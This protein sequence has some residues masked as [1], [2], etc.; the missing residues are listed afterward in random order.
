MPGIV[1]AARRARRRARAGASSWSIGVM[2]AS[3][4]SITSSASAIERRQTAGMPC[5]SSSVHRVGLAEPS[6]RQPQTPLRLQPE[7][8]VHRRGAHPDQ[9]HPPPQPLAQLAVLQRRDPQLGHQIAAAQLGQHPRVDL[10]GLARQ[11]RDIADLA[12]MRDLQPASPPRRACRAPRS[13]RSSS[14]PR[15]A[16]R[17]R[18]RPPTGPARPRRPATAPSPTIVTSL[19][20]RTPR[21]PSIRPIDPE[22]LHG[23]ASLRGLRLQ[24]TSVCCGRPSFM[25]F[26]VRGGSG[27][28][29]LA[30]VVSQAEP[31]TATLIR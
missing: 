28:S 23:R 7:D 20:Q 10:V 26:H 27:G 17:G 19:T 9:V 13:R 24:T 5:R 12:R 21:R 3:S 8:S 4:R 22:I 16:P 25:T 15:R 30:C 6:Q 11:R 2:R 1:S 31:A 14:P 18:A 29:S